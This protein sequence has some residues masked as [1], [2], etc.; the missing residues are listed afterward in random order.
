MSNSGPTPWP[1]NP[2]DGMPETWQRAINGVDQ[3]VQP[4]R[5]ES[6]AQRARAVMLLDQMR[7]QRHIFQSQADRA[8]RE[9]D[10]AMLRH[11]QSQEA[12]A[13]YATAADQQA[14]SLRHATWA[15]AAAT[16]VLAVAT[17][18]LVFVTAQAGA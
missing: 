5:I 12:A 18:V 8:A 14:A 6:A 16:V 2:D 1:I 11:R 7:W 17:V 13:W 15:L 3:A 9:A 4:N 10:D